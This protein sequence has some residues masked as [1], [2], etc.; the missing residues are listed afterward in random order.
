[1]SE[2][3][4]VPRRMGFHDAARSLRVGKSPVTLA[5][6]NWRTSPVPKND[7]MLA[8]ANNA[9]AS[10][11]KLIPSAILSRLK[12]KRCTPESRSLPTVPSTN[13]STAME[14]VVSVEALEIT[15][16]ETNA[17]M[18]IAA[19]SAEPKLRATSASTGENRARTTMLTQPAKNEERAEVQ[20]AGPARP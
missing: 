18:I 15:E 4:A 3:K 1:M 17:M 5:E 8:K 6:I 11:T 7:M 14:M 9:T 19:Y 10:A 20:S 13:P 12:V 16:T 2:P